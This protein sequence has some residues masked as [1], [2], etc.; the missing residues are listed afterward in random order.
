MTVRRDPKIERPGQRYVPPPPRG[1]APDGDLERW[2]I[3]PAG[4]HLRFLLRH[5]VEGEV[6]VR[7][8]RWGGTCFLDRSNPELSSVRVWVDV[9][10]IDTGT[11]ER[12]DHLRSEEF[13][14]VARFP[15]AEF[16][17]S[18]VELGEDHVVLRGT[19]ELRGVRHDADLEIGP[20]TGPLDGFENV[21][22]VHGTIDRQSFGLHWNLDPEGG[23]G[24][25]SDEV[26]IQGEVALVRNDEDEGHA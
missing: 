26:E 4:S 7:F 13:F 1:A 9:T 23:G 5:L 17:S 19:L 14:D 2:V 21:Y 18:A 3:D 22:R 15:R 11:P 8:S 24:I 12:D 6:P 10:S 20:R 25:L 16:R